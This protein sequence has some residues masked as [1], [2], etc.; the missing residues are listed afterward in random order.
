M[1]TVHTV[2]Q[3]IVLLYQGREWGRGGEI[4]CFIFFH[5]FQQESSHL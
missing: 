4:M 5:I 2:S 1:C 3:Y